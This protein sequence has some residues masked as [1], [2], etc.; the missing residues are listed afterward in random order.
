MADLERDLRVDKARVRV[1]LSMLEG[2]SLLRRGPDLPR[3]AVVCLTID[4]VPGEAPELAAFC[5]AARLRPF[6]SLTLDLAAMAREAGLSLYTVERRALEWADMGWLSYRAAGRD[7]L[8]EMLPPPPDAGD[9][10]EALLEQHKVIQVQRVDEIAGYARTRRCRHGHINSYLGGR[11]IER[12]SACDNCT[13]VPAPPD[14]RLPSEEEQLLTILRCVAAGPWSWGRQTLV[15]ILRG[16]DSVWRGRG[17]LPESARDNPCYGA[18]S[19]RSDTAV[20]RMLD[21]LES[22]EYLRARRLEHG[23]VVLDLTS[24]GKTGL[25]DPAILDSLIHPPEEKLTDAKASRRAQVEAA[26]DD[27]LFQALRAWRLEQASA[28]GVPAY[29]VFHDSHLRAIAAHK[30]AKLEA[31]ATLK[32]VGQRKLAQYGAAVIELVQQYVEGRENDLQIED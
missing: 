15:R 31:L 12:C 25:Q 16:D 29:V 17:P 7:M 28:R 21:R 8:L 4:N 26:S 27:D 5:G 6:Q 13:D 32:G 18:L 1:V 22:G 19:F 3:A 9:R 11:T 23:G 20:G 24:T 2:V 14:P 30:P 10:I